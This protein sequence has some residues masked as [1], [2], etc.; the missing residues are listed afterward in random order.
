METENNVAERKTDSIGR[1]YGRHNH[2]SN[3]GVFVSGC[4]ECETHPEKFRKPGQSYPRKPAKVSVSPEQLQ[5]MLEKMVAERL[6]KQDPDAPAE[7]TELPAEAEPTPE[8]LPSDLETALTK[9]LVAAM[10]VL[11]APDPLELE[12][13]EAE[14]ARKADARARRIEEIRLEMQAKKDVEDAC[15]SYGHLKENGKSAKVRGQIHNDGY[16]HPFCLRC[17]KRFPI[18]KASLE[19]IMS[20]G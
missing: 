3:F 15:E 13:M 2:G 20:G 18:E 11:K 14:K 16:Y 1:K 8:P 19:E 9:S 4:P 17:N 6:A 10:Q 7:I 5:A 12:K